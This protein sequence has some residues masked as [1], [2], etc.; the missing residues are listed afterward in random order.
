MAQCLGLGVA[1]FTERYTSLTRDRRGLTLVEAED[2]ACV[3][4]Q[5][6]NRCRVN[7]AKP[8]Q[9][10]EFPYAWNF[11]GWERLCRGEIGTE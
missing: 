8:R 7:S 4:L 6:D 2:G 3:F 11:P 5:A 10:R 1:E 9:C